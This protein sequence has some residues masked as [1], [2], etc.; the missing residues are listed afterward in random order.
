MQ[1]TTISRSKAI[2]NGYNDGE[3]RGPHKGSFV[4]ILIS[5]LIELSIMLEDALMT[6]MADEIR[7]YM[8]RDP[9]CAYRLAAQLHP[10]EDA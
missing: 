10:P 2:R 8:T 6:I 1:R 9:I 7:N 4:K 5:H 3:E